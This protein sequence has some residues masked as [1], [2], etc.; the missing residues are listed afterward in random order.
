MLDAEAMS[1]PGHKL[2]EEAAPVPAPEAEERH[3]DALKGGVEVWNQWRT[4]H[5]D[6]TPQLEGEALAGLDLR[7]FNLQGLNFGKAD[8]RETRLDNADLQDADLSEVESLQAIQ[9]AGTDLSRAELPEDIGKFERFAN[10]EDAS[11]NAR[12]L[13]LS[14][15]LVCAYT[16]LTVATTTDAALVTNSATSP[17]PIIGS[18]IPILGFYW[19]TPVLLLGFYTY[20]HLYSQRL[21]EGLAGMP[22]VFPDG[23]TL[24]KAAYPWL[25]NGLICA[26]RK[27]LEDQRPPMFRLQYWTSVF[28]AWWVVP[29]TILGLWGR[30][31]TRQDLYGT[32]WHVAFELATIAVGLVFYS[33]AKA[34]L[35]GVRPNPPS[36]QVRIARWAG[37]LVLVAGFGYFSYQAIQGEY[38]SW[39]FTANFE[40]QDVSTKLSRLEVGRQWRRS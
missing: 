10:I 13:F 36:Y 34:T 22:A 29:I 24:D 21:W 3:V 32:S 11:R 26:H 9:L 33:L 19:L 40:R 8:L 20:F 12:K 30:F 6:E 15:Q 39:A 14:M 31:L 5:L 18:R 23:T 27:Q 1:S 28:A 38:T 25:L 16:L 2:A 4:D 35:S 17:L 7:G 37:V